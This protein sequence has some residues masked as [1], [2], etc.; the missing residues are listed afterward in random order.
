MSV[1]SEDWARW[2]DERLEDVLPV[3][4]KR[5]LMIFHHLYEIARDEWALPI[6]N[7]LDK[8]T[9]NV[10]PNKRDRRL[11]DGELEMIVSETRKRKNPIVLPVILWAI[12]TGMRRGE[13]LSMKWKDIDLRQRVVLIPETKNGT[14]RKIPLTSKAVEILEGL[15]PTEDRVFPITMEAFKMTWRRIL[16]KTGIQGLTFHDLRHEAVSS[17]FE[18]GLNTPEVASISGHK[19]WR[20]LAIYTNPKPANIL[21]KLDVAA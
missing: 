19:D 21:K 7:P 8:V 12:E 10:T 15:D 5:Y 13:I 9:L 16:D 14:A 1:T 20:M 3:S 18:K 17:F 11:Q 2:R 6:T 4:V